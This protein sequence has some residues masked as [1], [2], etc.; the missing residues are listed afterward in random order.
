[1]INY[2]EVGKNLFDLFHDNDQ[3]ID[4]IAFKPL[5]YYSLDFTVRFT[6]KTNDYY[7][8]LAEQIWQY[9]DEHHEFFESRGYSKFDPKLAL[10]W[11]PIGKI[12]TTESKDVVLDSIGKHQ[13]IKE[14]II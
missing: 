1:M 10:G 4:P 12:V 6:D 2:C 7:R 8:V 14:I 9:Y 13:Y 11:L 5:H 3:Y